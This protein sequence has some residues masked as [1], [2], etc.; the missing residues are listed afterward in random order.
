MFINY[1]KILAT[2]SLNI[3]D[4]KDKQTVTIRYGF[5]LN[6][7]RFKTMYVLLLS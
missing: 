5:G 3:K 7:K 1:E 4:F 6:R 2:L